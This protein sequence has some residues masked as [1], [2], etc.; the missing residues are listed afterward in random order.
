MHTEDLGGDDGGDGEGVEN[1]DESLPGLDVGA[2]FA[3]V[4]EA[5][6]W[7]KSV[8]IRAC[9]EVMSA[10]EVN[11]CV[12]RRREVKVRRRSRAS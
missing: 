12:E 2:P 3:L 9:Q 7:K 8:R 4:V 11:R 10:M 6:Y 5:V 1:V